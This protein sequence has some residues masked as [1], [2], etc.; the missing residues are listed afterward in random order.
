MPT[1]RHKSEHGT[2]SRKREW[3]Q[4]SDDKEEANQTSHGWYHS[5]LALTISLNSIHDTSIQ[6]LAAILCAGL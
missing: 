3:H 6:Y 1:S 4:E 2:K 5:V